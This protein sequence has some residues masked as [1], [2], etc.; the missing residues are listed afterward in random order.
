MKN[1]TL[2]LGA[3]CF[4]LLAC[5]KKGCADPLADNYDSKV[6][7]ARNKDCV[8]NT[9]TVSPCGNQKEFCAKLD[10]LSING[11]M[12]AESFSDHVVLTWESTGTDYR[13]LDLTIYEPKEGNFAATNTNQK[14][15]FTATYV[16]VN[17]PR[18]QVSGSLKISHYDSA[19][20]ITGTLSIKFDDDSELKNG[21]LYRVE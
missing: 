6:V 7:K 17:G 11:Q 10:T 9:P 16:D 18:E 5:N 1:S 20:R 12:T 4:L 13:K 21:Y 8:Y 3:L 19:K 15:T 14:N 2:L